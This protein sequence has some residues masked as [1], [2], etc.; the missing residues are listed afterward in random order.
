MKQLLKKWEILQRRYYNQYATS[1]LVKYYYEIF[2]K[3]TE[4]N[5]EYIINAL[6]VDELKHRKTDSVSSLEYE[7]ELVNNNLKK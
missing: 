5:K 2:E 3:E 7:I 6:I 1:S 4:W